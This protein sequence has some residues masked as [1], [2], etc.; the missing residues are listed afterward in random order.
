MTYVAGPGRDLLGADDGLAVLVD[1]GDVGGLHAAHATHRA[2]SK[3]LI[4]GVA[5]LRGIR[6]PRDTGQQPVRVY[7]V[8][9]LII[10]GMACPNKLETQK[11][12]QGETTSWRVMAH[13]TRRLC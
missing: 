8:L 2:N 1:I 5:V 9:P 13:F 7:E 12:S 6:G 10:N 4:H 3:G 11:K